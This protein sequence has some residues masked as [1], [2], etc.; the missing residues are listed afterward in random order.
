[1]VAPGSFKAAEQRAEALRETLATH[2]HRYHTEDAPTI[3]DAEYDAL[4][5]ELEAIESKHPRLASGA[6]A[7]GKVGAPPSPAFATVAHSVPMLSLANAFDAGEVEEFVARIEKETGATAAEFSAEPK[8]DG[9]AISLRYEQ[10]RLVRAATRG[11]GATGEDVTANVRTIRAIPHVLHG[12]PAGVL[13]VRGEVF[14]PKS[15]FAAFNERARELGERTMANPRNGAAGSLRQLDPTVTAARPLAFYAY[16]AGETDRSGLPSS[17][18]ATLDWLR[19][20]GLPICPDID[21]VCGLEGLIRYYRRIGEAREALPYEIDGVVYK[22]NRVDQQRAMGFVSRAPRWALAHKYPAQEVATRVRAIEVQVGRTG[23][24]TPVARLDPVA[25][26]GVMVTNATLH[27]ADQIERLDVRVGD[28]VIVRRAGDVIP[29]VMRIN[30]ERRPLDARGEPMHPPWQMPTACPVCGSAIE[31]EEGEVVSRC[32]GGLFCGAQRTQALVHFASRRAMDIEGLGER[33]CEALVDF[34]KVQSVADLYRLRVADLIDMKRRADERENTVPATV[35][36]GKIATRWAEKLI[37]AID[38]SRQ[39][40]L[41]RLLFALGI[42]DVGESTARSL[43]RHFGSLDALL[44]ADVVELESVNDVGPVVAGRI[45]RFFAEPHNVEVIAELRRAGVS[46]PEGEPQ[47]AAEGPLL[48]KNFVLTGGLASMTREEAGA[49]LEALGARV[50][51]SVSKKTSV[52]VAGAAAGSKLAK[53]TE[54]GIEI[55][56]EQQLIACLS[57]N[58]P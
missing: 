3:T 39:T 11:D 23:S 44:A 40:S 22:L 12:Q 10:G 51:G 41:D 42:R 34:G 27:N 53:A 52:L 21:T 33:F 37:A 9:L 18:S 36:A 49:R 24:V 17:H 56:N 48:G 58:A 46:W 29:E 13:E 4:L 54:L 35:K 26:A 45:V 55:W 6:S 30:P 5:R 43:A 16:G 32:T 1:M 19:S 7:S 2:A 14:M 8:I 20:L 57:G 47:R 25:V 15:A 50:S 28:E 31:R 38:A